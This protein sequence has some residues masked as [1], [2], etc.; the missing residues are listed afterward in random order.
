MPKFRHFNDLSFNPFVDYAAPYLETF[1]AGGGNMYRDGGPGKNMFTS[2]NLT[3]DYTPADKKTQ[4]PEFTPQNAEYMN[5]ILNG[6]QVLAGYYDA[7][8]EPTFL[9]NVPEVVVTGNAPQTFYSP[10]DQKYYAIG[11]D[12]KRRSVDRPSVYYLGTDLQAITEAKITR[13]AQDDSNHWHQTG[14]QIENLL[15]TIMPMVPAS[16]VFDDIETAGKVLS[17][18]RHPIRTSRAAVKQM[19]EF[20]K[21]LQDFSRRQGWDAASS[22]TVVPTGFKSELDWSPENWF[23]RRVSGGYDAEDVAALNSHLAELLDI[24]KTAKENGTWL[25]MADGS[26]WAGDPREWVMAQTKVVKDNFLDDILTH[27]NSDRWIT[28]DGIDVTAE[29]MGHNQI[30]T[31]TNPLLGG[32]YGNKVYRFVIPKDADVIT[33]ADAEGR[34]F[35][36][37]LPGMDTNELVYP[38]LTDDNVI[39]INNVVDPGSTPFKAGENGFPEHFPGESYADYS[40][41]V[42]MGDDLVLG[43]NVPRKSLRGNN[44]NFDLTNPNIYKG[45][46]PLGLFGVTGL[47]NN[48]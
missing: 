20:E 31:S 27:G 2:P 28:K 22:D 34:L 6:S 36:N 38:R 4:M 11:Y 12:G 13:A 24:E 17:A 42:F 15:W 16:S 46:V 23:G 30:W 43:A 37:V 48:E 19:R 40:K 10:W 45:L 8:G 32:T 1:C 14:S 33:A 18:M 25:K 35:R 26:T 44:G 7:D 21:W 3:F 29:K 47:Y 39:R 5:F 9:K 41:R